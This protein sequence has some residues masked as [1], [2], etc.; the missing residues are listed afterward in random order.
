[1]FASLC[2]GCDGRDGGRSRAAALIPVPED[3][4]GSFK[5]GPCGNSY[6][7][8]GRHFYAKRGKPDD[9][10]TICK[11]CRRAYRRNH[12]KR[13]RADYQDA[14]LT[15]KWKWRGYRNGARQRGHAWG[16]TWD[17]FMGFWGQPCHYCGDDIE[18]VGLDRVD[19]TQGYEL[20]NVV[21]CCPTCNKMKGAMGREEWLA[22]VRKVARHMGLRD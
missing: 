15:P 7:R 11:G 12:Y 20:A 13:H 2:K 8:D 5:C 9:L 18:T 19:S 4:P 21:P 3:T 22:H 17:D 14:H 16:L 1:M 10:D 6:P